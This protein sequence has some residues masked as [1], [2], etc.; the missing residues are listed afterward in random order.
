M[1]NKI[2]IKG[3][4]KNNNLVKKNGSSI[5]RIENTFVGHE[6]KALNITTTI[7][8]QKDAINLIEFIKKCTPCF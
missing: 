8:T 6:L 5:K 4:L 7:R 2:K 1:N 3:L